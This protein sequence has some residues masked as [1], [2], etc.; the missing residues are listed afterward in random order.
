MAKGSGSGGGGGVSGGA[1]KAGG[2][3]ASGVPT[4]DAAGT[5]AAYATSADNAASFLDSHPDHLSSIQYYT[6]DSS[7]ITAVQRN[8]GPK[9]STNS[10][11]MW[12]KAQNTQAAVLAVSGAGHTFKGDVV[13]GMKG[14]D[15]KEIASWKKGGT[16]VNNQL[17]STSISR[18]VVEDEFLG[19]KGDPG[20]VMV[21][22]KQHSG[23]ALERV[24]RVKG[25]QEVLIAAGKKFKI[26]NVKKD[27]DGVTHVYIKE[28][29]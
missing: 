13:R 5:E 9:G 10:L 19:V 3:A 4:T 17:W 28:T 2:G 25:E 26:Q 18:K 15:A 24:T 14:V 23:V 27:A 8:G 22:A 6:N 29:R 20:R 1:G 16:L 12:Q 21:H 11:M 7:G